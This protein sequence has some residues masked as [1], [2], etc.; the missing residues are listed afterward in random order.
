[1]HEF[2]SHEPP[3]FASLACFASYPCSGTYSTVWALPICNQTS[4]IAF[5]MWLLQADRW[6]N[7]RTCSWN[8]S[9]LFWPLVCNR[10]RALWGRGLVWVVMTTWLLWTMP[11]LPWYWGLVGGREGWWELW[12]LYWGWFPDGER[13]MGRP[14]VG[15]AWPGEEI[16]VWEK[17]K[18]SIWL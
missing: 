16:A 1:M 9:V 4:N 3:V 11:W 13:A 15:Y 18:N 8:P 5:M 17:K 6:T 12:G 2:G 7:R 10:Q 14:L